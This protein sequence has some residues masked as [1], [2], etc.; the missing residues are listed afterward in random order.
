[1]RLILSILLAFSFFP[2]PILSAEEPTPSY[3]FKALA[4]IGGRSIVNIRSSELAEEG[5]GPLKDFFLFGD[6]LKTE[7]KAGSLGTGFIIDPTGLI[8]TNYHVVAPKPWNRVVGGMSVRLSDGREFPARVIGTDERLNVALL[9]IE[10]EVPFPSAILGDSEHLE[11]GEWVMAVGNPFGIET[12][13]TVGVVSGTGRVLGAGPYDH[14]IQTDA[15]IHAGNSGGPLLNLRGKVVGMNAAVRSSAQ[16]IGFATPINMLKKIL[17]PLE[18]E[19]KVTRGWL[20]VMI[21]SLTRDLARAFQL[22]DER[23][24]LVSQVMEESPAEQ[25]GVLRGDVIMTFDGKEVGEMHDLPSLVA[26]TPVG[27]TVSL[28]LVRKGRPLELR[29]K[30][31]RLEEN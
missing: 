28:A 1:M 6:Y 27:K 7:V 17:V 15:G 18:K 11:I 10:G 2:L 19:G 5:E 16:G 24:A 23:G 22:E 8:L 25:A 29:V 12:S 14:F 3:T 26:E 20:G 30:I 31:R 9:R 4:E 13:V 21:Q